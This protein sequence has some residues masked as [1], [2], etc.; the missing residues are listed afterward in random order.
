MR[1]KKKRKPAVFLI[2]MLLAAL[3]GGMVGFHHAKMQPPAEEMTEAVLPTAAPEETD[4]EKTEA[5]TRLEGMTL[6]EK[7]YQMLFVTPESIT[8]MGQV[9]AAGETTKKALAQYPVGGI[10]YFSPNLLTRE[11]TAEMIQNSQQFSEIP[12]F[13]GVDEEGGRVARLGKNPEMQVTAFPPMREIGDAGDVERAR[14]VGDTLGGE[15]RALG[16]NVDFAPVADVILTSSNTEIGDRAFGS[17]PAVVSSMVEAFTAG[18]QAQNVSA[19]LKHFP[20]HGSTVTDSH[21]GYS[22][23]RRT[24]EELRETELL[25]FAAGIEAG[26]DFVMIS[27]MTPVEL[28]SVPASL[29]ETVVTTLLR[30]ELGFDGVVIT[31]SFSMGAIT[32]N[33]ST[34]EAV[35]RAV[36]AGVDMILMPTDAVRAHGALLA[37]VQSGE[38]PEERIDE[39]VLRILQ[40]KEKRGLFGG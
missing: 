33:F 18:L 1:R 17:D 30:E 25:P 4:V 31:D 40:L 5:E 11:Q 13:I 39:S 28:D 3:A 9:T 37:A 24:L 34:K 8:G 7:L 35:T 22:E 6:E 15:L 29:S 10:I 23:S 21:T 38:I 12:L 20:G 14:S 2:I 36:L 26:A 32:D 27:H 19:V 16:F